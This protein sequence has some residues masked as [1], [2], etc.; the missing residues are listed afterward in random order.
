[1]NLQ[2]IYPRRTTATTIFRH[3]LI[4]HRSLRH[5]YTLH[6]IESHFHPNE[7]ADL[8]AAISRASFGDAADPL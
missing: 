5:A 4:T 8:A 7:T 1:M 3:S 6:I 2:N